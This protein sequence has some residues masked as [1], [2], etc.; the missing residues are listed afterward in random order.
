MLST[1]YL[2]KTIH[3]TAKIYGNSTIG[4]NAQIMEYAILGYPDVA[5]FNELSKKNMFAEDGDF[6]GCS[7]GNNALIRPNSTIYCKV[8]IKDNF[9][10]GHNI[11]IRENSTIGDNVLVGTNTIIDGSV[12]IGD[13]VSIQG[14]AYIPTNTI[15]ESNTFI[16]PCAV[17]AND[18][19]PIRKNFDLKGPVIR[20]NAS[21]GAN[22]TILPGIEIGEGAMI[23]AGAVVTKDVPPWKLAIGSPAKIIELPDD[24]K[25]F[26]KI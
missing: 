20:N 25:S 4:W 3:K 13:H 9:R 7:I 1:E 21:I 5:T 8:S 24:L 2:R 16:G 14:N 17:L 10:T 18:K 6:Q 23:A 15:I 19:Y 12:T 26:N 11:L 22:S